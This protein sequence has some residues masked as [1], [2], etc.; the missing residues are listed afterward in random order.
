M[1]LDDVREV[2]RHR[3]DLGDIKGLAA[4][5]EAIGLLQPVVVTTDMT[6]V[7]G[8]RRLVAMRSL[9]WTEGPVRIVDNLTDAAALMQA[10][11][12]ENTCRKP[13]TPSE[14]ESISADREALLKPLAKERQG[15]AGHDRSGKLPERSPRPRDAAATGTGFSAKTLAKVR[16][17]KAIIN[18]PETPEFVRKTAKTALAEMDA[19]GKVDGAHKRVKSALLDEFKESLGKGDNEYASSLY[20]KSLATQL[21]KTGE[22]ALFEVERVIETCDPS[23][24]QTVDET[25]G[26]IA[27]WHQSIVHARAGL[28]VVNGGQS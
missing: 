7:A 18:N 17:T 5:I 26:R 25:C 9:G 10:E 20:R 8:Q 28:H 16:E 4:S 11:A 15:N 1:R 3:T 23:L 24:M 6:L 21:V 12:D 19:T 13:F 22:L 27:R 2:Q 14:A